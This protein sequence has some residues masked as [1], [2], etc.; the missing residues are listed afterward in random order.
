M[1]AGPPSVMS[2]ITELA[3]AERAELAEFLRSLTPQ[4]W[5][6]LPLLC[7]LSLA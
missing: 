6:A 2:G 1:G 3:C 5:E 7:P 4:Q